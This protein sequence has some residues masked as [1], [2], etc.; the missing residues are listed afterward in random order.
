MNNVDRYLKIVRWAAER[1]RDENG[2]LPL[3]K[4]GAP[5]AY[6]RIEAAAFARHIEGRA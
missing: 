2:F 5:L 3:R 6:L 4:G 1:Y